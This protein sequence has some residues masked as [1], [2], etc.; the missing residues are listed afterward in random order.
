MMDFEELHLK[1]GSYKMMDVLRNLTLS[2]D[3][4]IKCF[5][6]FRKPSW[7]KDFLSKL[8]IPFEQIPTS[9][10]ILPWAMVP[11][12]RGSASLAGSRCS[13][14]NN[15]LGG[16]SQF[17]PPTNWTSLGAGGPNH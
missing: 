13:V 15:W 2:R 9:V 3:L 16:P 12:V 7:G 17:C 10:A 6:A 1:R 8:K 4:S 14:W 11:G 5:D